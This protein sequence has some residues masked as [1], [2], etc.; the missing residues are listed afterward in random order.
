MGA[1]SGS[2]AWMS[3]SLADPSPVATPPAEF[4]QYAPCQD[5]LNLLG[6]GSGSPWP[7]GPYGLIP[8]LL[9]GLEK[10]VLHWDSMPGARRT[11]AESLSL[12]CPLLY[13]YLTAHRDDRLGS[14]GGLARDPSGSLPMPSSVVI[15]LSAISSLSCPSPVTTSEPNRSHGDQRGVGQGLGA[16]ESHEIS[17]LGVICQLFP[18]AHLSASAVIG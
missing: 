7:S 14:R 15:P 10:T 13:S 11:V 6:C 12:L 2:P 18:S 4:E 8:A 16:S 9:S 5:S 17:L 3:S 1:P